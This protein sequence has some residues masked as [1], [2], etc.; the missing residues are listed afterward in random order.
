MTSEKGPRTTYNAHL[1]AFDIEL[2]FSAYILPMATLTSFLWFEVQ[3]VQ[4]YR[5]Y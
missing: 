3:L 2:F 1:R 4:L 5:V